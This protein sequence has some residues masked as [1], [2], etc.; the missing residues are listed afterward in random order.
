MS[1]E[2]VRA[3]LANV[4][5]RNYPLAFDQWER[6][7]DGK[8]HHVCAT[9]GGEDGRLRYYIDGKEIVPGFL[10]WLYAKA[11]ALKNAVKTLLRLG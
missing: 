9:N 5:K 4:P 7:K 11:K 1:K 10:P 8:W 3:Y 2:T 6:F